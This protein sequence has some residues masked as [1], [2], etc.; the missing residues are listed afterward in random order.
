MDVVFFAKGKELRGMKQSVR[1][2]KKRGDK[3]IDICSI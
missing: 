2:Y 3:L 1:D